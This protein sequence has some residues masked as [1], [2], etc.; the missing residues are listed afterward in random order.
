M[1]AAKLYNLEDIRIE[2]LPIPEISADEALVRMKACGICGSDTMGWY[3]KKKAPFFLGHEP[4]GIIEKVGSEVRDFAEGDR[5]FVHHHAPC[6]DCKF[7]RRGQYS[8]CPTWKASK[9]EPGGMAEFFRVPATNL[10]GDTL[11]L[12]ASLSFEDGALVEPAACVVKSLR[13][14][15]FKPDDRVLVIGLGVTGQMHVLM[16]KQGGA[17][18]II[19][20][21][22]VPYRLK[23]A[24]E[25]G[26]DAVVNVNEEN[27]L[28]KVTD[29]TRGQMADLVIVGP[30]T[31]AAMKTGI[32]C[33]GKGGTVLF[34][35]PSPDEELL[36]INPYELYFNE[37]NLLFSYSC[38]PNDTQQAMT[39][40]EQGVMTAEKFVT[41]KFS[42]DQTEE[43]YKVACEAKNSL[44]ILVT[45]DVSESQ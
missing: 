15:G 3:V 9:I 41:H 20:A 27:L 44:K 7:C 4:S 35:T 30:G 24:L 40:I 22:L 21:D 34:F 5:V 17:R 26:A 16:A 36:Q 31:T 38:G 8:L 29:L 13:Q 42:I 43:A 32:S 33:A 37:V 6:F 28:E 11:K 45:N 18:Q 2:E 23:R 39:L 1:R 10:R 25:F 12:P 19:G 14:A